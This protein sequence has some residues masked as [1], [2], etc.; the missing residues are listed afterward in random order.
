MCIGRGVHQVDIQTN[1][2]DS[3]HPDQSRSKAK[4]HFLEV[5]AGYDSDTKLQKVLEN[6]SATAMDMTGNW[7]NNINQGQTGS[8]VI[9]CYRSLHK[10]MPDCCE[11][12]VSILKLHFQHGPMI[13]SSEFP[14][15]VPSVVDILK[16]E[17]C[18]EVPR[19]D[20][21]LKSQVTKLDKLIGSSN[22]ENS[23][24]LV[25]LQLLMDIVRPL[26]LD[27][28]MNLIDRSTRSAASTY[29]KDIVV[30]LG[31]TGTHLTFIIYMHMRGSA[32][33]SQYSIEEN[34]VDQD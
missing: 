1:S 34:P 4:R 23:R 21:K 7:N 8:D 17:I 32:R 33:V 26:D 9:E 13:N 16:R 19:L 2:V 31:G 5:N 30:L 6:I 18:L 10:R 28:T 20:R 27:L 14:L 12:S 11:K 24:I 3:V 15:H 25:E 29:G 22:P